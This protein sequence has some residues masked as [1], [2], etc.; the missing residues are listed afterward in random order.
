MEKYRSDE[1]LGE[2]P[3]NRG[4]DMTFSRY[5]IWSTRVPKSPKI[6][7]MAFSR[8]IIWSGQMRYS[9]SKNALLLLRGFESQT[10]RFEVQLT[11]H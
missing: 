9:A 11:Y 6:C 7:N 10:K 3:K 8:Y 1:I 2:I 4:C 5:I